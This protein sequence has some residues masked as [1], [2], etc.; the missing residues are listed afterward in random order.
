MRNQRK[1]ILTT[2]ISQNKGGEKNERKFKERNNTLYNTKKII[3]ETDGSKVPGG[4]IS[5]ATIGNQS[6]NVSLVES[7]LQH[8]NITKFYTLRVKW[9]AFLFL[10][11]LK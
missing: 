7:A 11:A 1:N 5:Y 6:E 4:S 8:Q 3:T 9:I 2:R 10:L